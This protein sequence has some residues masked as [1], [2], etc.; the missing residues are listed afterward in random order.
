MRW[1]L[2][3]Q[4][5]RRGFRQQATYRAA[6]IAGM[7]TNTVFG[8]VRGAILVASVRAARGGT[9][10]GYDTAAALTYTWMSQALIGPIAVFRW[11]D[12]AER[13]QSGAIATD[14]ARPADFQSWWL[15]SDYG[16]AA[17]A[18]VYRSI[19]Q[20]AIGGLCFSLIVPTTATRW[21]AFVKTRRFVSPKP[22]RLNIRRHPR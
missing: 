21:L 11:S 14:L 22:R 4:L 15:A 3:W 16:R 19:A 17:C 2:W 20:F 7:V 1:Q 9:I 18:L 8:F 6:T 10:D 13:V 12:I 5:A